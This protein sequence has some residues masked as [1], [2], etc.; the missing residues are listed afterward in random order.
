MKTKLA[1]TSWF[2]AVI[3]AIIG[4]M[5]PPAGQIDASVLILIA[6]FLV[7]CATFLGVDSYV[8]IIRTKLNK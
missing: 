2:A 7:L 4:M 8:D 6:Q 1:T 3:F 5:L